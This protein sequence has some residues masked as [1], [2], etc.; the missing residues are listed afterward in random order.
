MVG[1]IKLVEAGQGILLRSPES[2][3][4]IVCQAETVGL[5]LNLSCVLAAAKVLLFIITFI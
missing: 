3:P 4:A 2:L 1:Q 5:V